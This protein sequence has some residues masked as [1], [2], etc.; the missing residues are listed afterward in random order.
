MW[1]L[2]FL[3]DSF[4]AF[5][6]NAVL[7]LGILGTILAFFVINPI[8]RW[9]PPLS[10]YVTVAQVVSLLVLTAG[11]YFKGG[12]SAEMQWRERVA[13]M[14]AQVAEAEAKSDQFNKDLTSERKKKQKV[15]TEVKVVIKERIKMQ[16][17][18]IDAGCTVSPEA[19]KTLN[20]SAKL[21]K[22]SVTVEFQGEK[23]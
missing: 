8:L 21:R 11:V 10:K 4:L 14:E 2:H 13:E 16:R 19:I 6:V 3:P 9:F 12:Y 23:K 17:E 1:L 22:G 15:R 7:V 18:V 20:D 5:V